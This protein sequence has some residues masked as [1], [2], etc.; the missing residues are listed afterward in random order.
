[1]LVKW[2]LADENVKL[3]K[4]LADQMP[5]ASA[6]RELPENI[7]GSAARGEAVVSHEAHSSHQ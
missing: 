3:K 2:A 1:M 5:E 6:L 7:A 4:L